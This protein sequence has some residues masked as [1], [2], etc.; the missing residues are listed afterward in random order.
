MA[1][2]DNPGDRKFYCLTIYIARTRFTTINLFTNALYTILEII[3]SLNKSEF[4]PR[5]LAMVH[6]FCLSLLSLNI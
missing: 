5:L 6:A 2:L 1:R 4:F 3:G